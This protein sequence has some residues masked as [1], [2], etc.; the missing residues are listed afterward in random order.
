MKSHIIFRNFVAEA[1]VCYVFKWFRYN[2][3]IQVLGRQVGNIAQTSQAGIEKWVVD[4]CGINYVYIGYVAC[5]YCVPIYDD[6]EMRCDGALAGVQAKVGIVMVHSHICMYVLYI[7][8]LN[9]YHSYHN[10]YIMIQNISCVFHIKANM[11]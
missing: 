9:L 11:L 3:D 8:Q 5:G 2:I 4:V 1:L 6:N 10:K 7:E